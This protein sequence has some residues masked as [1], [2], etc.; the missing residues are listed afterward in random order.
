MPDFS[1]ERAHGGRVAG[2]DEVGR[3][4]LAGPV[5]AAAVMFAGAV[6]DAIITLLDDSKVLTARARQRAYDALIDNPDVVIGL[7][8]ASVP[9]IDTH[10]I[11]RASHIAMVRAV[12]RL[13]VRPDMVLVDGNLVPRDLPCAARAIVGGDGASV[14]I[15]AASIVA[16][17]TRDRLMTR[18][19]RRFGAYG[20]GRNAGYPTAGHRQAM[21]EHGVTVHHRRSFAPV[22]AC[23][24]AGGVLRRSVATCRPTS[25][26][27]ADAA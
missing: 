16:K 13:R 15:A 17:V 7:A 20:W 10:N 12:A 18:L 2:V 11:L 21:L 25:H 5:V 14:S 23:L 26:V 3:G 24:A 27:S 19:D 4:P 8:A 22:K 9:E 1:H 6:P